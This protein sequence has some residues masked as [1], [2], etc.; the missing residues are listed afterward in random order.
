MRITLLSIIL[1][2][3]LTLARA[4]DCQP[5]VSALWRNP[6]EI[7]ITWLSQAESCPADHFIVFAES[8]LVGEDGKLVWHNPAQQIATLA[9]HKRVPSLSYTIQKAQPGATYLVRVQ[10]ITSEG[11]KYPP[12]EWFE[13]PPHHSIQPI[14]PLNHAIGNATMIITSEPPPDAPPIPKAQPTPAPREPAQREP[15]QREPA[16]TVG[17]DRTQVTKTKRVAVD[18]IPRSPCGPDAEDGLEGTIYNNDGTPASNVKVKMY[19]KFRGQPPLTEY[20][21]TDNYGRY[22]FSG[23]HRYVRYRI[24]LA[25]ESL[26]TKPKREKHTFEDRHITGVDLHIK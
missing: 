15:A 5:P 11:L 12:S 14:Q 9:A 18:T 4:Q 16:L 22:C 26:E 25:D 19:Y 13:V 6:Q 3:S 24:S 20:T 23:L 7:Q 1:A 8:Y 2:F 17:P 10:A 21:T